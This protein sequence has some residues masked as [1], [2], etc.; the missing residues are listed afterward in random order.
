MIETYQKIVER[1]KAAGLGIKKHYL[2]NKASE[3]FKAAIKEDDCEPEKLAPG[4]HRCNIAKRAIQTTKD[5][6]ISV[7]AGCVISFSMHLCCQLLAQAELPLNLQRIPNMA[8][9]VCA[10]AIVHGQH[11]FMK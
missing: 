11:N 6:F 7:L 3:D 2:D 10:Y 1:M 9:K 4:N 8:P 5:H